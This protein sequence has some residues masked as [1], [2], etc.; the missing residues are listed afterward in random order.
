[1]PGNFLQ[2]TPFMQVADVEAT[3]RFFADILGFEILYR[4]PG[5]A[6]IEREGCGIRMLEAGEGNPLIPGNRRF[7]YYVDVRDVDGLYAELKPKLDTLPPE[8]VHGPADKPY[9]QRELLVKVPDGDLIAFGQGIFTP[10]GAQVTPR[11]QDGGPVS[12]M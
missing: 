11:R 7:R 12:E 10:E 6:Y 5:Y 4:Q 9:G 8:D 2:I 1:M 3:A